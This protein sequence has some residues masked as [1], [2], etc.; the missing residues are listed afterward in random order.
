MPPDPIL[1]CSATAGIKTNVPPSVM[2][3]GLD[4]AM[5]SRPAPKL[6]LP[7]FCR[8]S[9]KYW[10]RDAHVLADFTITVVVTLASKVSRPFGA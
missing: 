9:T 5:A 7:I 1:K 2:A 4:R 3:V 10:F 6:L 8:C